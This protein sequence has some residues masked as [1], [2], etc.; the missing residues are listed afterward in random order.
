M[1]T[2]YIYIQVAFSIAIV[3]FITCSYL[4]AFYNLFCYYMPFFTDSSS[5]T[6]TVTKVVEEN[7]E[8]TLEVINKEKTLEVI[9]KE[10]RALWEYERQK[11]LKSG[12]KKTLVET[13]NLQRHLPPQAPAQPMVHPVPPLPIHPVPPLPIPQAPLVVQ[14]VIQPIIPPAQ[15][16]VHPVP[17][18]ALPPAPFVV[19][20]VIPPLPIPQAPAP[21]V[22]QHVIQPIIPPL[23]IPQATPSIQAIQLPAIQAIQHV[24]Q[25]PVIITSAPFPVAPGTTD[26]SALATGPSEA[27]NAVSTSTSIYVNNNNSSGSALAT[28]PSEAINAVST[29][30]TGPSE[31]VNS[32]SSEAS[33]SA[34]NANNNSEA[35][36]AV[37]TSINANNNNSSSGS[38]LATGPSE[39]INA[40]ST[41]AT[42]PS[43]AVN[44]FLSEASA[45]ASSETVSSMKRTRFTMTS[46]ERNIKNGMV[47]SYLEAYYTLPPDTSRLE[48]NLFAKEILNDRLSAQEKEY[49]Q[50]LQDKNP[51]RYAEFRR[52]AAK[53]ITDFKNNH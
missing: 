29:S 17:P 11:F 18:L 19:Q 28:G 38:A 1:L 23:P 9:E 26:A 48:V 16:M 34:I 8:K 6:D 33:A 36:N 42:G 47:E 7:K 3:V 37:S 46:M 49:I 14:P 24:L 39:A 20:P 21:L 43:E 25:Q 51:S 53:E 15:P 4:C 10:K 40:V 13:Y 52:I 31:A 32:S 2:N 12:F 22:V 30:A 5:T 45:E 35:V 41:S 44:S 27:V 50:N